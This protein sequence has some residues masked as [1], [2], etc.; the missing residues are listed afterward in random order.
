VAW[1]TDDGQLLQHAIV[2]SENAQKFAIAREISHLDTYHVYFYGIIPSIAIFSQ[3][4]LSAFANIKFY[5]HYKPRSFRYTVY[6]LVGIFTYGLYATATDALT[7]YYERSADKEAASL[8]LNYAK[9]AVEFYT[10]TVQRNM[11][12]RE[13]MGSRG[14]SLFTK[15]GN[16]NEIIR[17]RHVPPLIRKENAEKMVQEYLKAISAS[18]NNESSIQ[19]SSNAVA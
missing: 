15:F 6:S 19:P 10:K 18:N 3:Y 4:Y 16:H 11:A 12:I 8:G 2:L 1:G 17:Q 13:L 5:G 7:R 14:E 9:G